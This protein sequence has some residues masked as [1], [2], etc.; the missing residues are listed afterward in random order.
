[1][2]RWAGQPG[3]V[4]G[5]AFPAAIPIIL[6]AILVLVVGCSVGMARSATRPAA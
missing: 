2:A 1:M 6:A 5:G 3:L 4:A